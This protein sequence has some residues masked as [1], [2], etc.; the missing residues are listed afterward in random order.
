MSQQYFYNGVIITLNEHDDIW[1]RG[2]FLVDEKGK[3]VHVNEGPPPLDEP[4]T[5]YIDLKGKWVLP[6]LINT[7][8]HTGMTMLRGHA[9]DLPL[10][11]WLQD[12]MWPIE[13][14]FTKEAVLASQS[15]AMV[16]ML[17]SGTTTFLDMYH[18]HLADMAEQV[19]KV[20]MRAVMTRGMIGLCSVAEQKEKIQEAVHFATEYRG[21]GDGRVTTMLSPH[22]VYT[23][24]PNFIEMV[25]NE[26][27]RH[28]LP[29]HTHM[30]ETAFEVEENER[31][32]GKRPVAHLADLGFFST[33]SLVAHAVHVNEEEMELLHKHNVSVSYNP[34]S[35][36]KLGSGIAPVA[37]MVE[38]GIT[39]AF[40][41]DSAASNNHLDLFEEMRTGILIQKGVQQNST[42]LP[43]KK[44]LQMATT[45][46]AEALGL[47][48]VGQIKCGYEADFITICPDGPHFQP[49]NHIV[50]HLVY[51]ASGR[52]VNDVYVKGKQL[53]K[54]KVCT[55]MDEEKIQFELNQQY[56]RLL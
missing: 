47:Q 25:V 10:E 20:G 39:V 37:T 26:A 1:E 17:K 6:G 9:D 31:K 8:G 53:V 16:E 49:T 24:P 54:D 41:T 40:G 7:H 5:M 29:L 3:V 46:G 56:N 48:Y 32:Y 4:E 22:A 50:S 36:L 55:T 51:T 35:N 30:S 42:V 44:A 13:S 18:L 27:H 45:N 19:V 23:C 33:K 2:S 21:A 15:L 43:A 14:R 34:M 12:K 28:S 52:D 38:K 11:Q